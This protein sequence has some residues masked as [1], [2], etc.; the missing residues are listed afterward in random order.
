MTFYKIETCK[1]AH[2]DNRRSLMPIYNGDFTA[3]QLK[4]LRIKE[5]SVLGNHYHNY[6]ECFYVFSG[7]PIF[8]LEDIKSGR[9]VRL[10]L[11]EGDRLIIQ[12]KVAHKVIAQKGTIMIESTER[13]YISPEKNDV[14]YELA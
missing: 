11:D 13:E 6:S 1:V 5:D 12:P 7:S 8:I 9:R 10:P 4:I 14:R 3:K 2:E